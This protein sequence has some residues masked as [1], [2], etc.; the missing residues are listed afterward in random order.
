[1]L[2]H[3][4]TQK[5]KSFWECICWICRSY[6]HL[7][8][9]RAHT[10]VL[11]GNLLSWFTDQTESF[12]S[13]EPGENHRQ[14]NLGTLWEPTLWWAPC[15]HPKTNQKQTKIWP[16][17]SSSSLFMHARFRTWV[18]AGG[19]VRDRNLNLK[20]TKLPMS[21]STVTRMNSADRDK[22]TNW[23]QMSTRFWI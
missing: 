18:M 14:L 17:S 23:C 13:Y 7:R 11:K 5:Q 16:M 21:N 12:V 22:G 2:Y 9:L 10:A 19:W 8:T 20:L 4:V 3:R 15:P 1:V 6:L